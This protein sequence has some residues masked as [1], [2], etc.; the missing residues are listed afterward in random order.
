MTDTLAFYRL[1][2]VMT[3]EIDEVKLT[4]HIQRNLGEYARPHMPTPDHNQR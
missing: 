3:R 4:G 2:L 1:Q